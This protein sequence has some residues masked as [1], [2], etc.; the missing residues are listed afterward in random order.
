MSKIEQTFDAYEKWCDALGVHTTQD[1]NNAIGNGH[2]NEI[3]NLSEIWH[4]HNISAVADMI[5]KNIKTKKLI[6]IAGPSSSGKTSFSIRL[7]L[8]LMVLGIGSK[9]I[10]LDDYYRDLSNI[11]F[12]Q[13][14]FTKFDDP[15]AVDFELFNAHIKDIINGKKVITPVFDFT[16]R[17]RIDNSKVIELKDN[18]VIIV[19]GIHALNDHIASNIDN[20]KKCKVYCTALTILKKSNGNKISSQRTRLIRRMIRDCKFRASSPDITFQMWGDVE[21]AAEK[22]IY[23]YTDNADVVFNSS[24]LYE[25][26]VY[27]KYV[28]ELLHAYPAKAEYK[29]YTDKIWSVINDFDT[30]D[31][32]VVPTMSLIREFVGGSSLM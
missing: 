18:E 27:K 11:P 24:V 28:E 9:T 14:D 2:I 31:L 25:F 5:K 29:E 26:G 8:H 15:D 1:L 19:E 7:K 21:K 12:D 20:E 16:S 30:I 6:L 23:P 3:V 22:Y 10:S 32:G 13:L 17:K 4:E